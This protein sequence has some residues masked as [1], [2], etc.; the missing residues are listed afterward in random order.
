MNVWCCTFDNI[1][2][3]FDCYADNPIDACYE[4]ILKL[5]ELY[6]L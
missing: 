1:T 4:M 5:H 6:L 2:V 3:S